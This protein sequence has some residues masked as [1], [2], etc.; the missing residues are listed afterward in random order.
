MLLRTGPYQL[1][2]AVHNQN[3]KCTKSFHGLRGCVSKPISSEPRIVGLFLE[4]SIP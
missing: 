4:M 1:F 2:I 3:Y